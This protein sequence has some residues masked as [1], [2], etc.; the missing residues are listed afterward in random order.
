MSRDV[1]DKPKYEIPVVMSLGEQA[2]AVGVVCA[3]GTNPGGAC[4]TGADGDAACGSGIGADTAACGVGTGPGTQCV[5]GNSE[6][7]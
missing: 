7:Q 6:P 1:H 2:R 5:G 3:N 4:N